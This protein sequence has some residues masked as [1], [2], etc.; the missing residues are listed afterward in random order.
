MDNDYKQKV[1]D[2]LENKDKSSTEITSHL[3]RDY[4]F[5]LKLL[6]EMEG[7]GI[8]EKLEVGKFTYWRVKKNG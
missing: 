1:I 8:I 5:V 7:E 3:G 2:F 4:Y 6:E